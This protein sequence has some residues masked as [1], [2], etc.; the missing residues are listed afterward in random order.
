M[1]NCD[2]G[3]VEFIDRGNYDLNALVERIKNFEIRGDIDSDQSNA[4][5]S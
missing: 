5:H 2:Q 3:F 4:L 1:A